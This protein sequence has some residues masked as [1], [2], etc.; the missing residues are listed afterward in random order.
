[1]LLIC[2]H[3]HNTLPTHLAGQNALELLAAVR[4]CAHPL[5][6]GSLAEVRHLSV[7]MLFRWAATTANTQQTKT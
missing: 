6:I 5:A 3:H 4:H 7:V 1:M 2:A